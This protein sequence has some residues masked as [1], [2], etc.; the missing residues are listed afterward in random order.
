MDH[1][2]VDRPFLEDE[3]ELMTTTGPPLIKLPVEPHLVGPL[4]ALLEHGLPPAPNRLALRNCLWA[5]VPVPIN[6][7]R[8]D[9]A[10]ALTI[11]ATPPSLSA[12]VPIDAW[13]TDTFTATVD[14]DE[15][16]LVISEGA[17]T[18]LGV[19]FLPSGG[20]IT[21]RVW[22]WKWRII[23]PGDAEARLWAAPLRFVTEKQPNLLW[24]ADG[25]T[26]FHLGNELRQGWRFDLPG[27]RVFLVPDREPERW[28]IAL[29]VDAGEVPDAARLMRVLTVLGFVIG[30]PV[31]V[32]LLRPVLANGIGRGVLKLEL[33][34]SA[35]NGR[36]APA[37][38][39]DSDFSWIVAF[40]E[41]AGWFLATRPM[42]PFLVTL[43]NYF[44]A[45][46]GY[47][48]TR[49]LSAWVAAESLA[50]WAIN[51]HVVRDGK[52][53]RIANAGD[54]STWVRTHDAE[55]RAHAVPGQEQA[56]VQRVLSSEIDRPTPVQRLF[57]GEGIPWTAQMKDAEGARHGV[58][59]EGSL[60]G[61]QPRDF[62]RDRAR[63]GM[64]CTMLAAIV[65]K[66]IG[67]TGPLAD[68]SKTH[69]SPLDKDE[70]DW[71]PSGPMNH[72]RIV[73][74]LRGPEAT[75]AATHDGPVPSKDDG[76]TAPGAIPSA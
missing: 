67:Y 26:D 11:D 71:W 31:R 69:D 46:H 73:H 29:E 54:W 25:N 57:V 17:A 53:S 75:T 21:A 61:G 40:V 38:P 49:F 36:Q 19:A 48:D 32:G 37:M 5:G 12:L 44:A 34:E 7:L 68:R 10:A 4:R 56:L 41:Q 18:L 42:A 14:D 16:Q 52:V 15:S 24:Y 59:H 22:G 13:A 30:E 70:P 27:G 39:A 3:E 64:A 6:E 28:L 66:C 2:R 45:L 43:H 51:H 9:E 35:C 33:A 62:G 1:Q 8:V 23:H 55:I 60:L 50:K 47:I 76:D 74:V 63:L 65:A 58:A 72:L 20:G